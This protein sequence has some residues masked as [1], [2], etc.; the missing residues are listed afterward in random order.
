MAVSRFGAGSRTP[1][2]EVA[3]DEGLVRHLLGSQHADLASLPISFVASGW[4]NDIFRLGENLAVRLPRRAAASRLMEGEQRF[5][6]LLRDRL[7]IAVPAPIRLGAPD[8]LYPWAWSVTPWFD[9]VTSDRAPPDP[10]EAVAL[11][12]FF[13]ALHRTPPPG[14]PRNP[15]RGVGLQERAAAFA[16]RIGS[17]AARDEVLPPT[18]L[19]LW[20]EAAGETI[21]AAAAWI[22][23]DPHARNILVRDGRIVAVID[24]GD[25]TRGDRASDLAAFWMLFDRDARS[26]AF[27]ALQDVSAATWLRARGWALLYGVVFL[28]TGLQDD[29]GMVAMARTTLARLLED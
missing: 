23:G 5:L 24:W 6:K 22:H 29:P 11:A 19:E 14:L 15:F 18:L 26:A 21:D 2:A 9:G 4:D 3:I 16:R 20:R 25:M 10:S 12:S 17:L 1:P 13:A 8:C 7:P 28:D 27:A